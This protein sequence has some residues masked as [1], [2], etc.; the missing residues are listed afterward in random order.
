MGAVVSLQMTH[1]FKTCFNLPGFYLR[2]DKKAG[3]ESPGIFAAKTAYSNRP[4]H[5]SSWSV[6]LQRQIG[7]WI[8]AQLVD[9]TLASCH[10]NCQLKV[11]TQDN[12]LHS[13]YPF[14]ALAFQRQIFTGWCTFYC[15]C[16]K[17]PWHPD[18]VWRKLNKYI[19]TIAPS[20]CRVYT[21]KCG[22]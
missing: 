18:S 20:A 22:L 12:V 11:S 1:N 4:D 8:C 10:R 19:S 3:T 17:Y 5:I 13:L 16:K 2:L 15:L 21:L 6:S 9:A 7:K 14:M